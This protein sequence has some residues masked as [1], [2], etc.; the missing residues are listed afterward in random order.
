MTGHRPG[1][2]ITPTVRFTTTGYQWHCTTPEGKECDGSEGGFEE[3]HRRIW[4]EARAHK[5]GHPTHKV[6][7]DRWQTTDVEAPSASEAGDV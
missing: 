1:G 3:D 6:I 2:H 7:V 5:D 4:R